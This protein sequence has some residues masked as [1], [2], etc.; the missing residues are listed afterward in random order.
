[1]FIARSTNFIPGKIVVDA[2]QETEY[3][4][5]SVEDKIVEWRN[6][7]CYIKKIIIKF[8]ITYTFIKGMFLSIFFFKKKNLKKITNIQLQTT[9]M[10]RKH[11]WINDL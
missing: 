9:P 7:T 6:C 4:V 5:T 10:M 1:M 11:L 3:V 8:K 2:R